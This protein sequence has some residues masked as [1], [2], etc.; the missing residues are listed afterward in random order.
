M[1]TCGVIDLSLYGWGAVFLNFV[2]CF[3]GPPIDGLKALISYYQEMK[4]DLALNLVDVHCL[5]ALAGGPSSGVSETKACHQRFQVCHCSCTMHISYRRTLV[6]LTAVY[7]RCTGEEPFLVSRRDMLRSFHE[8]SVSQCT[9]ITAGDGRSALP[10]DDYNSAIQSH[11]TG[12]R[13]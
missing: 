11:G 10:H 9:R 6:R 1:A 2:N 7:C 12:V 13:T 5:A 4:A 8:V 3:S